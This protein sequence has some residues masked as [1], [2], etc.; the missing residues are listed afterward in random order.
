M[1][2]S[3]MNQ[4]DKDSKTNISFFKNSVEKFIVERNWKKFHKPKDLI[5]ALSVEVAELS[6]LF[7]FKDYSIEEILENRLL[8]E[9]ISDEIADVFIYLISLV[10][11]LNLDITQIFINKMEKNQKKYS[12]KEF[13]N[14]YYRKK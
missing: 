6:E 4:L 1:I 7:L 12:L 10:N 5:H 8:L 11:S 13:S 9:N 2:S 3:I 14:G